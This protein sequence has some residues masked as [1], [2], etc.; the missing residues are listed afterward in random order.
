[1]LL[2]FLFL[3]ALAWAQS[4]EEQIEA[5]LRDQVEAWNKGDIE[6]YMSGYWNSEKTTFVSG[7][8]VWMGFDSVLTRYKRSYGTRE[9]MGILSFDELNI[10]M[11]GADAAIVTGRWGLKRKEDAPWGRFTLLLERKHA[12]WRIVYDHTS[13]GSE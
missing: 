1:M 5:V 3:P 4:D 10:R 9:K 11:L 2:L 12:G 13:S 7:G 8:N 6:G